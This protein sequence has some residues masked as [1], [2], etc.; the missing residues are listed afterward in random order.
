MSRARTWGVWPTMIGLVLFFASSACVLVAIVN[1]RDNTRQIEGMSRRLSDVVRF[2]Q[3]AQRTEI[4]QAGARVRTPPPRPRIDQPWVRAMDAWYRDAGVQPPPE[5]DRLVWHER[6]LDEL[7]AR[8]RTLENT[9][10]QGG[11]DDGSSH[12][13][14]ARGNT[15]R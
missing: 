10:N 1:Q 13:G 8:V 3:G 4:Q 11:S 12:R 15:R 5:G 2:V 14:L 7:E 9:R 6:R